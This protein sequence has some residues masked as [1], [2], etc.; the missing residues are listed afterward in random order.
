MLKLIPQRSGIG[1]SWKSIDD[2][3][4][5]RLGKGLQAESTGTYLDSRLMSL[6]LSDS[7]PFHVVLESLN[8]MDKLSKVY[9]TYWCPIVISP[10]V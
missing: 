9:K 3:I 10:M 5:G 6:N 8:K 1:D 4:G 7:E 2:H